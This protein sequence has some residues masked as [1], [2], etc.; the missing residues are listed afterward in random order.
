MPREPLLLGFGGWRI[1]D[2]GPSSAAHISQRGGPVLLAT[3]ALI[4]FSTA[5]LSRCSL[6]AAKPAAKYPN[7]AQ[8]RRR[9]GRRQHSKTTGTG[10]STSF[11]VMAPTLAR[12]DQSEASGAIAGTAGCTWRCLAR[13]C[14]PLE[15]LLVPREPLLLGFGGWRIGDMGPSSAAHISQRGGPVLLATRALISFSTAGLSRRSL[16]AAKPA[17]KYPNQAQRRR[18]R[19]GRRQHSETTGTGSCS[20]SGTSSQRNSMARSE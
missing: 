18:R 2:M 4:S 6:Q 5:G 16:Q 9:R 11:P 13:L 1:G 19:R 12:R 17:A 7:Q 10:S 3:R 20:G 14:I 8:Q 15:V